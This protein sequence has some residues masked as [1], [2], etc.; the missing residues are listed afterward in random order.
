MGGRL[1]QRSILLCRA[2]FGGI[3]YSEY[4]FHFIIVYVNSFLVYKTVVIVLG[5]VL[6]KVF[7]RKKLLPRNNLPGS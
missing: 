2:D 7:G 1:P 6:E 4:C 5:R 3:F